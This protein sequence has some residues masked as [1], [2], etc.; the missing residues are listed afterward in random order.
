MMTGGRKSSC[1][2]RASALSLT[3]IALAIGLLYSIPEVAGWP[4][5]QGKGASP[6]TS[7]ALTA[8]DTQEANGHVEGTTYKNESLNIEFTPPDDLQFRQPEMIRDSESGRSSVSI[9]AWSK[10]HN[11]FAPQKYIVDAGIM[12]VADRLSGYPDSQRTEDG[13]MGRMVSVQE[14]DGF[15][16]INGKTVDKIG[17]VAFLRANFIKGKRHHL[18]LANLGKQ[19]AFVFIFVANDE[20]AAE[21]LIKA[22]TLKILP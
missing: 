18:V 19:Y 13:Y 6:N 14:A 9:S 15:K 12:F 10:P 8:A 21:A 5:Q 20:D 11:R 3:F 2:S 17:D 16:Q 22:T 7:G 4:L 1:Q